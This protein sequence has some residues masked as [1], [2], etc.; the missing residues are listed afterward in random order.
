MQAQSAGEVGCW[1]SL[2]SK[3]FHWHWEEKI[4]SQKDKGCMK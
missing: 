4:F 3:F 1:I 2:D